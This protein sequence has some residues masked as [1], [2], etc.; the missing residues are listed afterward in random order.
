[1][2]SAIAVV[3][4]AMVAV[5]VSVLVSLLTSPSTLPRN[6]ILCQRTNRI[7][8]GIISRRKQILERGQHMP[9]E[10]RLANAGKPPVCAKALHKPLDSR[11]RQNLDDLFAP[12]GLRIQLY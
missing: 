12:A 5:L 7:K 6:Q 4:V 9:L 1:M 3:V 11:I 10:L 8:P 2:P